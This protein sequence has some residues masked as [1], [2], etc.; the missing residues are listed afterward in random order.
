MPQKVG[1]ITLTHMLNRRGRIE[2]ETT[3]VRMAEDRFY[4]VCAAFFEQRLL[5]HLRG[6]RIFGENS[7]TVTPVSDSWGALALNG[8][9]SREVLGACTDARL[10]NAAFRWLS[11]QEITVAGHSVWA[12][13]MSYAGELGWELHMPFDAMADVYAA[14]W[15]AGE[16]HG[17]ADYGSFA[18]N[19]M[20]MEKGFKGAGELTNEVTLAEADVL[21]FARTDKDYLGRDKTLNTD[22]PWVC[23]Y[24]EIEPDGEIDGHGGEAVIL[25][26][27]VVGATASVAYGHTVGKILAFAYVK[28]QAATLGTALEVVIHG[29]PRAARVLGAPAY[30]PQSLKPRAD[31]VKEPAE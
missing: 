12:F 19:V 30:D 2:L 23:A 11:A 5:D 16:A 8:P 21:R 31:A 7:T 25:D 13:R 28:P 20:R 4:L 29:T 24:L 26:G 9:R 22:L 3:I 15:Q 17:I 10:D 1:A 6:A 14:L 27:R 18:M